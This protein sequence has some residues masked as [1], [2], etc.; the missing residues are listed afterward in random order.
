MA[1]SGTECQDE[2]LERSGRVCRR[3][4]EGAQL[5]QHRADTLGAGVGDGTLD[6][7]V[8][9]DL[10]RGGL[11]E[12]V[13]LEEE[14][15]VQAEFVAAIVLGR[16]QSAVQVPVPRHGGTRHFCLLRFTKGVSNDL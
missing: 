14:P 9:L 3:G 12:G 15:H 8:F 1:G 4:G 2:E 13:I 10:S 7:E 11:A 6:L 16:M 5:V